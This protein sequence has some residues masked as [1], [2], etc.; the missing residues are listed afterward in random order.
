MS[1]EREELHP[2]N[3]EVVKAAYTPKGAKEPVAA[4]APPPEP[5]QADP[6]ATATVQADADITRA[7]EPDESD[8]KKG[9]YKTRAS[10][11]SDE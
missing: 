10:R 4:T 3:E 8:T 2:T 1:D 9:S 7:S 5:V 6:G 11:K